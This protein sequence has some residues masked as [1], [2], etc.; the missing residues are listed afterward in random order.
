MKKN[1]TLF[2]QEENFLQAPSLEIRKY[3]TK[4]RMTNLNEELPLKTT[5]MSE[6]LIS[7]L[8]PPNVAP[9]GSEKISTRRI[10]TTRDKEP[11]VIGR[12]AAAAISSLGLSHADPVRCAFH[13]KGHSPTRC[14]ILNLQRGN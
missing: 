8:L 6:S 13:K 9:S 12:A 1:W 3:I 5:N 10:T 11:D 7:V 14:V 4:Q 2:L